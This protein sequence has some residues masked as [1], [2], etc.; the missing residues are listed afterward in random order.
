MKKYLPLVAGIVLGGLFVM[1]S[2][3]FFL[4]LGPKP[5]FPEG[6]PIA[7]YMAAFE[8]TGLMHFVKVFELLGGILVAIPRTRNFGLL[9]LGP[10]IANIIAFHIF[11]TGPKDLLNPMLD[12]IIVCA[13]YLLWVG[14]KQFAGLL[15]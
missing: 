5:D 2:V 3:M 12:V 1:A 7:H 15:N 8:S 11:I 4:K 9:V 6:S 10:I 13:L 14:R